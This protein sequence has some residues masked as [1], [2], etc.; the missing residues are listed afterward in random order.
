MYLGNGDGTFQDA[1]RTGALANVNVS[2]FANW[3][4]AQGLAMADFNGDGKLDAAVGN[5]DHSISIFPGNGD[6]TFAA[7]ITSAVNLWTTAFSAADLNGDG[8]VRFGY[9]E[10]RRHGQ[11]AHRQRGRHVQKPLTYLADWNLGDSSSNIN[12]D[13]LALADLNGDG[14][15][16]VVVGGALAGGGAAEPAAGD[17][18]EERCRRPS[19]CRGA[20]SYGNSSGAIDRGCG[21][22]LPTPTPWRPSTTSAPRSPGATATRRP[23]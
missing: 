23:G 2:G 19:A 4:A 15:L 22:A 10:R 5:V 21:D 6:G 17:A 14:V 9:D 16:D 3:L 8:M 11:P 13:P 1:I 12:F 18:A 7:P 20:G